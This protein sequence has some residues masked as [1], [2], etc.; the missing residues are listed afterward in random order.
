MN[1]EINK[2]LYANWSVYLIKERHTLCFHGTLAIIRNYKH[3]SYLGSFRFVTATP[4]SQYS[5]LFLLDRFRKKLRWWFAKISR[6]V[7]PKTCPTPLKISLI[8]TKCVKYSSCAV[9]III[10]RGWWIQ[11]LSLPLSLSLSFLLSSSR[12]HS[13]SQVEIDTETSLILHFS[14]T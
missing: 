6:S 9:F 3:H 2:N 13:V 1:C 14:T 8:F 12:S 4:N 5:K 11:S 7:I 10:A